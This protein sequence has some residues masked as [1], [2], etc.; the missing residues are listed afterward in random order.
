MLRRLTLIIVLTVAAACSSGSSTSSSGSSTS[1]SPSGRTIAIKDF[2]FN[3]TPLEA[4]VGDTITV[5]NQDNTDHELKANDNSF[6]TGRFA[7]G[8]K[9]I[10][11]TKA[12]EF[13]YH[14][15]V[16]DYMTGV[17]QVAAS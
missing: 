3:P 2:T 13:A 15:D 10:T 11:V 16:H 17:I 1:S 5:T 4:K 14:C 12:G 7:T 6:T 9:T 8:A